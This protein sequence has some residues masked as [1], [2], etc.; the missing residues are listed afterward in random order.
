MTGERLQ[1]W[2]VSGKVSR[3][4]AAS[5]AAC[6][7]AVRTERATPAH[8]HRD[9]TCT[10]RVRLEPT[11]RSST[12]DLLA[13]A[14][15]RS[16]RRVIARNTLLVVLASAAL[17][18]AAPSGDRPASPLADFPSPPLLRSTSR[19]PGTV[20]VTITAAPTRLSL[21]PGTMTD[22][23]SYNGSVPGPTLELHEG[24]RVIIHFHNALPEATSIHWHGLH[25]PAD[26]D[27]SPLRPVKPG[28]SYE[29]QFKIPYGTAGTYWYH[30]HPDFR[31][32]YQIGKGLFGAIVVRP[33]RDPLPDVVTDKLLILADNR[34]RPDGSLDFP[35]RQSPQGLIDEVNGREGD[36]IFVNGHV[37]PTLTIRSGEVQRWRVINASAAR[38]LR[39]AI[40]G[41]T[42]LHVG[43]DGGLF[44]RPVEVNEIVVANSERVELLVRGTGA[45]GT[46]TTLQTLPYDRYVPQ[47][48][49]ANWNVARDLLTLRYA[50]DPPVALPM[51][52]ATLR[53]IA[54]LD[55]SKVRVTRVMVLSQG[56]INGRIMNMT[57]PDVTT[58]LGK[59]EIWRIENVVGMDHPF[60]LHGFQFQVLDRGGVPE[61]FSSW[62][63]VVNVRKHE[64]VRF[65]VRY[66]DFPGDWMFHCHI[67]DHE[68]HG[69]MGVLR[70]H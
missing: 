31:T 10:T 42:M 47:T 20:E 35:E 59:T 51:L 21:L 4:V 28:G 5:V 11:A 69:M 56:M 68:D 58:R 46:S 41:Q 57:H 9:S 2:P 40:P 34:F 13:R 37:M 62:K 52:P 32:G 6:P 45:P 24:D 61:P 54:P 12:D 15:Q 1:K 49:P 39:L 16:G 30:P 63:D 43:N 22:A 53:A 23:Y 65:I 19:T 70:V 8:P 25:I 44:E 50:D 67:L 64:T 26:M 17:V 66:D 3:L 36:V 38:V 14:A 27:G 7:H 60:H 18:G 33:A 48:R 29:Y 55:T